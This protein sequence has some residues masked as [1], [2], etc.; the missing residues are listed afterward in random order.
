VCHETGHLNDALCVEELERP[1]IGMAAWVGGDVE[2]EARRHHIRNKKQD[3][4]F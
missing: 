2:N 1:R 4:S 3:F